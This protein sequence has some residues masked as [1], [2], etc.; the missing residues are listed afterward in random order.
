MGFALA[1]SNVWMGEEKG[2]SINKYQDCLGTKHWGV[3]RQTDHLTGTSADAPQC[4]GPGK[5]SW[6]SSPWPAMD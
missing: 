4:P 3:S 1:L 2:G 6:H 5:M